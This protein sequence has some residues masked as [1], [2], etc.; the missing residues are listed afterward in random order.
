E[1]ARQEVARVGPSARGVSNRSGRGV[2]RR[3]LMQALAE[4]VP[5]FLPSPPKRGRG[6]GRRMSPGSV[7]H[8]GKAS[9]S[10]RVARL[11]FL[12]LSCEDRP[13]FL[14]SRGQPAH[15]RETLFRLVDSGR[16]VPPRAL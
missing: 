5:F 2:S 3:A 4:A 10:S 15:D 16:R 6:E 1:V 11:E 13:S 8:K 14:E 9:W 12:H 7:Y